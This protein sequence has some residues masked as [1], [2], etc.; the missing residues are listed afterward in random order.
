MDT[1]RDL[2]FNKEFTLEE[3]PG[4]AVRDAI[5]VTLNEAMNYGDIMAAALNTARMQPEVLGDNLKDEEKEPIE[6]LFNALFVDGVVDSYLEQRMI[7]LRPFI[8]D[9][10][11]YRGRIVG[12]SWVR[13]DGKRFVGD[14][15]P[16]DA[17]YF[18]HDV[19]ADGIAWGCS[20]L[21]RSA[22]LIKADY[23]KAN[24]PTTYGTVSEFIDRERRVVYVGPEALQDGGGFGEIVEEVAHRW[25]DVDG[26]PY[27]P[28]NVVLSPLR[29]GLSFMMRLHWSTRGKASTGRCAL[30]TSTRIA[31][32]R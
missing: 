12:R 17:R 21:K 27:C 3:Q 1:D 11:L 16:V 24:V 9:Q 29:W 8:T 18:V 28:Y 23:P 14:V 25:K 13:Q 4:R 22:A 32:P 6:S 19:D 30:S 15:V 20:F 2:R 10:L 26:R 5:N 7:A 31:S